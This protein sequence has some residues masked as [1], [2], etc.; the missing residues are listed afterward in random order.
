MTFTLYTWMSTHKV[1]LV[2]LKRILCNNSILFFKT[3]LFQCSKVANY[4]RLVPEG[5][6]GLMLAKIPSRKFYAMHPSTKKL[7]GL[8]SA[9][10]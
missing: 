4:L 10:L 6:S 9:L 2:F 7:K 3:S 8:W 5:V 1:S